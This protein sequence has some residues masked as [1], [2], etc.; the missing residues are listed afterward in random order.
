MLLTLALA[1]PYAHD[2]AQKFPLFAW[3]RWSLVAVGALAGMV[4]Y[5]AGWVLAFPRFRSAMDHWGDLLAWIV[6]G[7]VYGALLAVAI[8][9]NRITYGVGFREFDSSEVLLLV[10][11]VPWVLMAQG[12]AEMI[13]V[14]LTS[15][16]AGSDSD[17]EWLGRAA[18]WFLL[19][20]IL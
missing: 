9:I 3:D 2:W 4:V 17:R 6:A 18:G 5:G 1:V 12:V 19:E 16:E 20:R 10:F 11:G 8:Y 15:W 13:F 7:A 14:G